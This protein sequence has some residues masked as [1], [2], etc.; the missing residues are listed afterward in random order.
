VISPPWPAWLL[1]GPTGSGKSP[2][3]DE[4]ERRGL[5]GRRCVHFDFGA[6]LRSIAA[7]PGVRPGLGEAEV[8]AIRASLASGALF[9][10]R[11]LAMIVKIVE[12]FVAARSLGPGDLLVL[13]G[14]PRHVR[15]A[16]RLEGL[17]DVELVVELEADAAVVRERMRLDPD[18]ERTGRLD[19]SAAAVDRRVAEYFER[20]RPLLAHYRERGVRLVSLPVS[21][22]TRAGDLYRAVAAAAIAG[23]RGDLS[24]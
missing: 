11:D 1:V 8:E 21:A 4:I 19:G 22:S 3:G 17:F 24:G 23:I 20:T 5:G 12:G 16:E 2:L 18:G 10:D 6:V 13:N 9:E 14:L 15:Q 7:G